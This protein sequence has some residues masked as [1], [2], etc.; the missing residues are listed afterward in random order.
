MNIVFHPVFIVC[1]ILFVAHQ[2]LQKVLYISIPL[3]DQYLDNL[4]A[5]P[6]LLTLLVAEKRILFKR[7]Q[8]Y[9]L[10]VLE[11]CMATI[12]IALVSEYLFP[13]LSNEFIFDWLDIVCYA[14]GSLLFYFTINTAK[15]QN[16]YEQ[17]VTIDV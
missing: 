8:T 16:N 15:K 4:V 14:L 5:P 6:I 17:K 7:S 13:Y 11:V 10:S 9:T 1:C 2:I 3:A 12:L